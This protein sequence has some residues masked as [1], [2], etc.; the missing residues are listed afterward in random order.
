MLRKILIPLESSQYT[1]A[2]VSLAA[3]IAIQVREFLGRDAVTLAG[4]GIVDTDQ[5]PSGRFASMVPRE[6]I[7]SEAREKSAALLSAFRRQT[8]EK[9]IPEAFVETHQTEGSAFATIMQHHVFCDLL[10]MGETC[11][12]PPAHND[13]NTLDHLFHQASRPI[14]I[15]T[16]KPRPI[17]AVV[18]AMDGTACASRMMYAYAHLNPFPKA[19][20]LVAHTRAEEKSYNLENFFER[21]K[22]YLQVYN[23]D[24]ELLSVDGHLLDEL[25]AVAD[26]HNAGVIAMG[27]HTEHFMDKIRNPLALRL[28]PGEK[29]LQQS[30]RV[31]FT[32]H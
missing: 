25:P 3:D 18:M 4:L 15:T 28:S 12:F 31:L 30:R 32:V 10:V 26:A 17:D 11:S 7:L 19:K 5:L 29:L 1:P 20:L 2:A 24:V 8:A 27:V 6:E 21:V 22:D 23:F 16:E 13:Y 14:L 9:G